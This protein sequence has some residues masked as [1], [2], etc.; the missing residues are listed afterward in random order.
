M[1][2]TGAHLETLDSLDHDVGFFLLPWQVV[3]V[4]RRCTIVPEVAPC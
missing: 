2:S 3:E 1:L 4:L